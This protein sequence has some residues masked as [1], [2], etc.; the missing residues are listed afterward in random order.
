MKKFIFGFKL[1]TERTLTATANCS[2]L[3]MF[4][5]KR[6]FLTAMVIVKSSGNVV[7]RMLENTINRD[8]K[9]AILNS[10]I[11]AEYSLTEV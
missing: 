5:E 7:C 4:V 10:V 6:D 2:A 8:F 11:E 3:K 9:T 1:K